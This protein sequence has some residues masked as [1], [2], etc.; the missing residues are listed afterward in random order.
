MSDIA[1]PME[2]LE[3]TPATLRTWL[4][5]LDDGWVTAD[6]GEGTFSPYN[7]V[8]HLIIGE[9]V[10]WVP[11]ARIILEHGE[12]RAFDPFPHRATIEPESGQSMGELLEEFTRLRAENL[13][14]L[15]GMGLTAETLARRG[16]HPELGPVTLEN[17]IWTWASHDVHHI[18]QIAKGF[19]WQCRERIGPWRAYLGILKWVPGGVE[20]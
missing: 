8:G 7:V 20:G 9:R 19:A 13:A 10:D 18:G 2:I 11:R 4:G 14:A 16:V 15:R 5:G 6:Y 17:L 3:A 1:R 12:G